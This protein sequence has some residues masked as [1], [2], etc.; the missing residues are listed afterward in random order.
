MVDIYLI[1]WLFPLIFMFH[2]FEE[3]IFIKPW[4]KK[5]RERIKK[6]LPKISK[7]LLSYTDVLTTSSFAIGVM[8]MYILI[9]AVTIT[10]YITGWHYIW[11]G[12][13]FVFTVHL[14]LHCLPCFIFKSYVPASVTSVICLPICCYIL[15]LF[16]QLHQISLDRAT[17][18]IAIGFV[19]MAVTRIAMQILM[20]E[21]ATKQ[22]S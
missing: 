15:V 13:F 20:K 14:F 10:A 2:D 22:M 6:R 1:I 19:L 18:Y 17:L 12:L 7:I 11:F 5:N 21:F 4:F 8:G 3:I 16:L 9:C